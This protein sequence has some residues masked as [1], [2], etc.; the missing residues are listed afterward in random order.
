EGSSLPSTAFEFNTGSIDAGSSAKISMHIFT[1][2]LSEAEADS[3]TFDEAIL[4]MN[5]NLIEKTYLDDSGSAEVIYRDNELLEKIDVEVISS[6]ISEDLRTVKIKNSDVFEY[7]I[8]EVELNTEPHKAISTVSYNGDVLEKN[9]YVY[10]NVSGTLM[11]F[12]LK[13]TFG[14]NILEIKYLP[15]KPQWSNRDVSPPSPTEWAKDKEYVFSIAWTDDYGVDSVVFKLDGA[16]YKDSNISNSTYTYSISG[17]ACGEHKYVWWA[18]DTDGNI[19]ETPEKKYKITGGDCD[20]AVDDAPEENTNAAPS[21]LFSEIPEDTKD[22]NDETD[23]VDDIPEDKNEQLDAAMDLN[24]T[25]ETNASSNLD[26]VEDQKGF[27]DYIVSIS[28]ILAS[29]FA[30]AGTGLLAANKTVREH[31]KRRIPKRRN[32]QL[33]QSIRTQQLR[34][35]K[36]NIGSNKK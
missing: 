27:F 1:S 8:D 29:L 10:N 23:I 4:R 20:V 30:L 6:S 11:L 28:S 16:G 35:I 19:V 17:L 2:V 24:E 36:E 26:N 31:V 21:T 13:A 5:N 7:I 25:Q 22:S 32:I 34:K 18:N 12:D 15:F 14:T 33:A 9:K 3:E